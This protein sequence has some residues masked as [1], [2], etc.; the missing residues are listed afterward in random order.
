MHAVKLLQTM[1]EKSCPEIHQKRVN[2]LFEVATSLIDC[3][4]LLDDNYLNRLTT[5]RIAGLN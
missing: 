4:K 2:C 1:I 5:I 3:G